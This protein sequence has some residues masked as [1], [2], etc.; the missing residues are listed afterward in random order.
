METLPVVLGSAGD[1]DAELERVGDFL[2]HSRKCNSR[3]ASH[4]L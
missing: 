3:K 1:A 2:E 4:W